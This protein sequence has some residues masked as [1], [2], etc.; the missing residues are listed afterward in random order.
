MTMHKLVILIFALA[1]SLHIAIS[2]DPSSIRLFKGS[3]AVTSIMNSKTSGEHPFCD[4][5]GDPSLIL[6]T[7]V[8]LGIKK[9]AIMKGE[10]KDKKLFLVASQFTHLRNFFVINENSVLEGNL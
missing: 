10:E 4:L 5:P 7:N 2:F 3:K 8:D 1:L 9:M 6:T